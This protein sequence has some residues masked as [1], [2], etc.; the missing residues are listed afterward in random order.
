[1]K[2][3]WWVLAAFV[4]LAGCEQPAPTAPAEVPQSW[5]EAR[6]A[7]MH[8][9]HLA[10]GVRCVDCHVFD[11]TSFMTL[12][13]P[14]CL[15]CH[16]EDPSPMH[17][18]HRSGKTP[19]CLDCHAFLESKAP[20]PDDC[21]TCHGRPAAEPGLG[22][23]LTIH[24]DV[25][26]RTCHPAH[27]PREQP[28]CLSCHTGQ[29]ARHGIDANAPRGC[30]TCHSKHEPARTATRACLACHTQREPRISPS[31]LFVGGHEACGDCH[32]IHGQ[33]GPER[34]CAG[35]HTEIRTP[36]AARAKNHKTCIS[37][38]DPHDA[39][40]NP[41]DRCGSCHEGVKS[42]HAPSSGGN[43][44][45][46]CHPAHPSAKAT[47]E[48]GHGAHATRPCHTCHDDAAHERAFH[49]G[50]LACIDCHQGH[51]L[52]MPPDR[53]DTC[54]RCHDQQVVDAMGS[55]GHQD[56]DACHQ[57][58]PHSRPRSPGD[59]GSCHEEEKRT[60]LAGHQDCNACHQTHSGERPKGQTCLTCHD[61][62][63]GGH[64]GA[65]EGE[66]RTCHLPH[67]T[68]AEREG[69]GLPSRVPPRCLTCHDVPALPG[70]HQRGEHQACRS[71]HGAHE[72]APRDD[73]ATCLDCHK[74]LKDHEPAAQRCTGCH[75][76]R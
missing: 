19:G 35:C 55:Q 6:L 74:A 11:A 28:D 48:G 41:R 53:R 34:A 29:S 33:R 56:C 47:A 15:G 13:V 61:T 51:D 40:R 60:A 36:S 26:C 39:R 59:C 43:E 62:K 52:L 8:K 37:C 64:H 69:A 23:S 45:L 44:C 58:G 67:T 24:N 7:G 63:A 49:A 54:K 46:T 32:D 75:P 65:F 3:A 17:A 21:S 31:T 14:A 30:T 68:R 57:G 76:F 50:N 9:D 72:K 16:G 18:V 42:T 10:K 1:M 12:G 71:C 20:P 66:C 73:R 70:L 5:R 22:P 38:H 2:R 25:A 4:V 27:G